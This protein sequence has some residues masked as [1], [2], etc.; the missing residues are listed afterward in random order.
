M[1]APPPLLWSPFSKRVFPASELDY[2]SLDNNRR[3]RVSVLLGAILLDVF[4]ERTVDLGYSVCK[5]KTF[6]ASSKVTPNYGSESVQNTIF[7]NKKSS[8][9]SQWPKTEA[10]SPRCVNPSLPGAGANYVLEKTPWLHG[11]AKPPEPPRWT[12]ALN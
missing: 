10:G 4:F 2:F 8:S 3:F 5:T 6:E 12:K 1:K 11:K 7:R 9:Q